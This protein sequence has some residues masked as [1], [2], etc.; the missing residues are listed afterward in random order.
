MNP[1]C[2]RSAKSFFV[3]TKDTPPCY[4]GTDSRSER[5][6]QMMT[7]KSQ[8]APT[9]TQELSP[10]KRFLVHRMRLHQF[11][12]IEN[13]KVRAGEPI[14]NSDVRVVRIVRLGG[15]SDTAKVIRTDEF[16][17]KKASS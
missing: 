7:D 9:R 15:G 4:V 11:G 2:R 14:L 3:L 10:G 1:E 16:E 6:W 12:R 13:I 5:D 8:T 17:L